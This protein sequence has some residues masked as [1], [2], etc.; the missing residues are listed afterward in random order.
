LNHL[1]KEKK[2]RKKKINPI[3]DP[4]H[5]ES[6]I[7]KLETWYY[8]S[9]EEYKKKKLPELISLKKE[10]HNLLCEM[11]IRLSSHP[12]TKKDFVFTLLKN[13]DFDSIGPKNSFGNITENQYRKFQSARTYYNKILKLVSIQSDINKVLT[14]HLARHSYTSLML[15]LGENINLFDVMTSLGHKHLTTTQGYIRRFTNNKIDKLNQI[16]SDNLANQIISI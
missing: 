7:S 15:E 12:H 11:I 4:L 3:L 9:H 2:S 6:F 10:K 1:I 14:T 8:N 5:K 13:E 16:I